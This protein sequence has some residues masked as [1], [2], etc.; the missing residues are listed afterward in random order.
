[1]K[2]AATGCCLSA[3]LDPR[4][5]ALAGS[6]TITLPL[7]A[8]HGSLCFTLCCAAVRAATCCALLH[9]RIACDAAPRLKPPRLTPPALSHLVTLRDALLRLLTPTTFCCAF[10]ACSAPWADGLLV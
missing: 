4:G 3:G 7:D 5:A 8:T 6:L 1:M 9:A 2:A 10:R